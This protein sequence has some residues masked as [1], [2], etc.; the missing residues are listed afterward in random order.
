MTGVTTIV[1]T[2]VRLQAQ[3]TDLAI[4]VNVPDAAGQ[5][6]SEEIYPQE[7]TLGKQADA[8][9]VYRDHILETFQI[10]DWGLFM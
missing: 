2:L 5:G 4:T 8:A 7:G 9:L 10:R 6:A 3:N 1:L